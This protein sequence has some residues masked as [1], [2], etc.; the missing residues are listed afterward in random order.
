MSLFHFPHKTLANH[1][2]S[3]PTPSPEVMHQQV[4]ELPSIIQEAHARLPCKT[5]LPPWEILR[6]DGSSAPSTGAKRSFDYTLTVEDFIQDVKKRRVVPSYDSRM[7]FNLR[8]STTC[9]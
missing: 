4:S 3:L 7:R 8:L 6:P 9:D 2:G 5:L 1:F